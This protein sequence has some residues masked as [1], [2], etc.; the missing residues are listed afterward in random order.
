ML[1]DLFLEMGFERASIDVV[2]SRAETN[3]IRG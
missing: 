2:A 1:K 3:A